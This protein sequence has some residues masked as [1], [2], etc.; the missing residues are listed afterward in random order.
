M[1]LKK[2]LDALQGF[3]ITGGDSAPI[4][5]MIAPGEFVQGQAPG[6]FAV[7]DR[8]S[9][10]ADSGD[11][12]DVGEVIGVVLGMATQLECL[13]ESNGGIGAGCG[14]QLRGETMQPNADVFLNVRVVLAGGVRL[15]LN[16]GAVAA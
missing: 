4:E 3:G 8:D 10:F 7:L 5:V 13:I 16:D 11:D 12:A 6:L 1:W 15:G 9:L 14:I 2:W